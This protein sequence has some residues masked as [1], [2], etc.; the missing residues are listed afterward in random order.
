MR[1]TALFRL[2]L[3]TLP[4]CLIA[5]C[6]GG[7]GGA[8]DT[9]PLLEK[10]TLTG[11]VLSIDG[12]IARLDGVVL[13]LRETGQVVESD[14]DGWF[15]FGE[16]PVGTL[17][18]DLVH[19]ASY[20]AKAGEAE[21]TAN[22]PVQEGQDDDNDMQGNGLCM[23]QVREQERLHVRVRIQDGELG[24]MQC[25]RAENTERETERHMEQA[26]THADP[27]M[28]GEMEM[29]Q[30]QERERLRICVEQAEPGTDLEALVIA[31]DGTEESLGP[32]TV[33]ANGE[34]EW[35]VDTGQGGRLPHGAGSVED[36]EGYRAEV[37]LRTTN[38][39][40]LQGDLPGLPPY[41]GDEDAAREQE[42]TEAQEQEQVQDPSGE[43]DQDQDRDRDGNY[44][45]DA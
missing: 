6:G 45:D 41:Q 17:T 4:L 39:V 1:F 35:S 26:Q 5:A 34:C 36:L 12:D 40:M 8:F 23:E 3:G 33:Q 13:A 27:D 37:R 29:E 22:G 30:E 15:S 42:R 14:A 21:P 38:Q 28:E 20:S 31:P 7:G 44:G 25:V 19:A 9:A 18:L 11:E 16:V 24:E 43:T 2:A 10:A 32:R